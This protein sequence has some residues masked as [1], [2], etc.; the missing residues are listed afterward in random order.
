MIENKKGISH[1]SFYHNLISLS[2]TPHSETKDI[3]SVRVYSGTLMSSM[4][5][6]GIHVSLLRLSDE[7]KTLFIECLD[8]K[9]DAPCWPGC[10][11]SLPLKKPK[12]E[13]TEEPR[14]TVSKIG[15][16]LNEQQEILIQKCLLNACKSMIENQGTL[17][18]LDR[19][20]GDGDCGSTHKT[21]ADGT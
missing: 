7:H 13:I 12:P 9:T 15:R 10:G 17:N 3:E 5:S 16:K 1:V 2:F 4:D 19:G 20:C 18:R 14:K 21:L 11:Y 8:D 6:E